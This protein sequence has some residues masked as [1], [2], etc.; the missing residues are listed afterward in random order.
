MTTRLLSFLTMGCLIY[1]LSGC[2]S[3]QTSDNPP[4]D[5]SDASA[6]TDAVP[7]ESGDA[8][9]AGSANS[10]KLPDDLPP[11]PP[12]DGQPAQTTQATAPL[13]DA[14]PPP[15]APE[16]AQNSVP[17]PAAAEPAPAPAP[18]PA[19]AEPAPAPAPAPASSAPAASA[20]IAPTPTAMSDNSDNSSYTVR[21]GDT[22]MRIAFETCGDLYKWKEIYEANRDQIKDPN[23]IVPG[24]VLKVPHPNS[25]T[26][27]AHNGEK[28]L[29]K[30]GETLGTISNEVYGTPHKWKKI[31]ENNRDLIKDPN[32]IFAGFFVYYTVSPSDQEE[33]KNA[34]A[35]LAEQQSPA[36]AA[37]EP[38]AAAPA[39]T[40]TMS[41]APDTRSPASMK[42]P[43]P[44]APM[45]PMAMTPVN[46]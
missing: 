27:V 42:P 36:P 45:T 18:A 20:E 43:M 21:A 24:A 35:P 23:L 8:A 41:A 2:S 32:L 14:T 19:V 1:T 46:H 39:S 10:E 31:F 17:A 29:I 26:A 25:S 40:S 5:A 3:S 13:N 12:I 11:A 38:A 44:A 9:A 15:A 6:G 30:S 7:S 4:D 34:P 22:L 37:P 16:L 33:M 28:H